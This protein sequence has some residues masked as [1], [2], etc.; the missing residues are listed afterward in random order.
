MCP[1]NLFD[2]NNLYNKPRCRVFHSRH[3]NVQARASPHGCTAEAEGTA[4]PGKGC[5]HL[6][7][8]HTTFFT[9]DMAGH[10]CASDGQCL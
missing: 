3:S 1:V 6:E 4:V 7:R 10:W 8:S 5:G 2:V 9:A